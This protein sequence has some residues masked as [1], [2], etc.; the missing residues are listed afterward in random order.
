MEG[1]EAQ[2]GLDPISYVEKLIDDVLGGFLRSQNDQVINAGVQLIQ[3]ISV[4]VPLAVHVC[5]L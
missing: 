2:W 5:G 1:E 3:H 4:F